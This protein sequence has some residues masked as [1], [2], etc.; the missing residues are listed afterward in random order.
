MAMP[1]SQLAAAAPPGFHACRRCYAVTLAARGDAQYKLVI[2]PALEHCG[3]KEF[4]VSH[5]LKEILYSLKT[6]K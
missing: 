4:E 6:G 2:K 3:F 1:S 5:W